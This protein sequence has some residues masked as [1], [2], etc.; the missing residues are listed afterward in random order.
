MRSYLAQENLVSGLSVGVDV[1][2]S[3]PM[4]DYLLVTAAVLKEVSLVESAAFLA[5][6]S[7]ILQQLEQHSRRL[8]V[9][10]KQRYIRPS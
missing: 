10:K 3:K 9:Q 6:P 4:G 7:L 1:T 8:Q 2:A 5:P